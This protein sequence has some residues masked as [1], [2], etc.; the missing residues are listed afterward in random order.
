MKKLALYILLT[1]ILCASSSNITCAQEVKNNAQLSKELGQQISIINAEIKTMKAKLKADPSNT[2]YVSEKAR[3]EGELRKAK[4][5]KKI[6]DT[7]IKASKKSK[8]ETQQA[9]KANKKFEN[10][11]K[12]A[13]TLKAS[14]VE[15]AGKSNENISDEL[16]AK[17]D[18]KNAEIKAL[19]ARKK[20][21]P[22]NTNITGEIARK[23]VEMK[24]LKRQKKVIDTAIKAKKTS[25]KETRQAEKAQKKH[26][27]AIQNAEDMKST[28]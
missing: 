10:A 27:K 16:E 5:Q 15:M 20:S 22:N 4:E 9:E 18:I 11:T 1:F 14:K 24:E 3:W 8:K 12:E 21:E 19:K 23:E 13:E 7:E 28:M 2:D 26:E 25:Q 6:I 17:V